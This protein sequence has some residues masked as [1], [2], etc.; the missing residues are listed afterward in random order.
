MI[1]YIKYMH[2]DIH[3]HKSN[4]IYVK[5]IAKISANGA[6]KIILFS[7]WIKIIILA[8]L[9]DIF[10]CFNNKMCILFTENNT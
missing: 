1:T 3:K 6:R 4:Y 8:Q 7:L 10:A 2:N 5:D 9:A